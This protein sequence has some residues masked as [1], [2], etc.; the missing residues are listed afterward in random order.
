MCVFHI[1]RR[2][3]SLRRGQPRVERPLFS[4]ES[5][6]PGGAA[7]ADRVPRSGAE[8]PVR[9][10]LCHWPIVS[11]GILRL[12]ELPVLLWQR[13]RTWKTISSRLLPEVRLQADLHRQ[14]PIVRLMRMSVDLARHRITVGTDCF[15]LAQAASVPA[16]T[17]DGGARPP[18]IAKVGPPRFRAPPSHLT[19]SILIR[20]QRTSVPEL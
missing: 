20:Q 7:G 13:H 10:H 4:Y 3:R 8:H 2:N 5:V 1:R 19:G 15:L 12:A 9:H 11:G 18:A 6:G 14:Q 17:R 16:A